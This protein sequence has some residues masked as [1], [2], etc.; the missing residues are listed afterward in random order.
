MVYYICALNLR[1]TAVKTWEKMV[2]IIS[3][4]MKTFIALNAV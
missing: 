2:K 3:A 1:N 4:K